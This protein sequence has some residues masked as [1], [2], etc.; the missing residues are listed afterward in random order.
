MLGVEHS[1]YLDKCTTCIQQYRI[2]H[3]TFIALTILCALPLY[4]SVP[5][6]HAHGTTDLF[7]V[8]IVLPFFQNII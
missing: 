2:I 3:R 8:S 1:I 6:P 4:L 5:Y 7:T